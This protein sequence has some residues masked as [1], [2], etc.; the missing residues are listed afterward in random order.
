MAVEEMA[1]QKE[2]R[3]VMTN[4]EAEFSAKTQL[5][6]VYLRSDKYRPRKA[7]YFNR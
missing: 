1:L 6:Q 7:R 4:E 3:K 5:D 2:A